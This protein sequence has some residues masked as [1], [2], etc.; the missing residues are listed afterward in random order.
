M[1]RNDVADDED[2]S[3]KKP[4]HLSARRRSSFGN[5]VI[6]TTHHAK[7][8]RRLCF[9]IFV[10]L[11]ALV[12]SHASV[13]LLIELHLDR[14]DKNIEKRFDDQLSNPYG[15]IVKDTIPFIQDWFRSNAMHHRDDILG[16]RNDS[17][18]SF[19]EPREI[20]S[21]GKNSSICVERF[22]RSLAMQKSATSPD[23]VQFALMTMGLSE[24]PSI[25]R[26]LK[27]FLLFPQPLAPLFAK[28]L[29]CLKTNAGILAIACSVPPNML[30]S[31]AADHADLLEYLINEA[32]VLD[33]IT[34]AM[35]KD[36][37]VHFEI[38][39]VLLQRLALIDSNTDTPLQE[40][41][42][43]KKDGVVFQ[44]EYLGNLLAVQSEIGPTE[45][46][47]FRRALQLNILEAVKFDEISGNEANS[48]VG[49]ALASDIRFGPYS[50][51]QELRW[52]LGKAWVDDY[53]AWNLAFTVQLKKSPAKLLMPSVACS[54]IES[55]K[56][57]DFVHLHFVSL[58]LSFLDN[59]RSL[60]SIYND[61]TALLPFNVDTNNKI[62]NILHSHEMLIGSIDDE[63]V[64]ETQPYL[65]AIF[66]DAF[67]KA[68]TI[69]NPSS[70][71]I[72]RTLYELCGQFCHGD[73]QWK[74]SST[75]P[76]FSDLGDVQFTAF[77]C[78]VV[79]M[80]GLLGGIGGELIV[81]I[82]FLQVQEGWHKGLEERWHLVQLVFSILLM[83]ALGLAV[84]HNYMALPILILGL[85]KFGFPETLSF[86]FSALYLK[87]R[88]WTERVGDWLNGVGTFIHHSAAILVIAALLTGLLPP[89]RFVIESPL[90]LVVQHWFV[91][92]RYHFKPLYILIELLL[93]IW[94]EWII[95]SRLEKW[96]Y[97][98]HLVGPMAAGIMLMAHWMYFVAGGLALLR[99]DFV[100]ETHVT[101]AFEMERVE[102][103]ALTIAQSAQDDMLVVEEEEE[104]EGGGMEEDVDVEI[105]RDVALIQLVDDTSR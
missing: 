97:E 63:A 7:S 43:Y 58:A 61:D 81:W 46:Q 70:D 13:A 11:L 78:F 85:F 67:V 83:T 51:G 44:L 76:I 88:S 47:A 19:L 14:G 77:V 31:F 5:R 82:Y 104:L 32:V 8:K 3:I 35:Y 17:P 26:Y 95:F 84:Y 73:D 65:T 68:T 96:V 86:M 23:L 4:K 9:V 34:A 53:L 92:L 1:D 99:G 29:D 2:K 24:L 41:L 69:R 72:E 57:E 55:D 54:T 90:I 18:F 87:E 89:E 52:P 20:D 21:E 22:F 93:E 74:V 16:R 91:L 103:T 100:S 105:K 80:T 49:L 50:R 40:F 37:M 56:A 64:Y 36:M 15:D 59:L 48:R 71:V 98:Y 28:S 66:G 102:M 42:K 60:S 79:W 12:I 75:I 33:A 94:F 6:A 30:N 62:R 101:E 27:D 38:A 45:S 10:L 39:D 25:Q